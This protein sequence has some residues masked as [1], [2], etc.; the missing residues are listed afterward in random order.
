[1][2]RSIELVCFCFR[3]RE[4]KWWISGSE[5]REPDEMTTHI[6]TAAITKPTTK[7]KVLLKDL[8]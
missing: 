7:S 8:V 6:E 3:G 2:G 4:K 5:R 1:M